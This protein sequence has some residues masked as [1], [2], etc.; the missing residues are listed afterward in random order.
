MRESDQKHQKELIHVPIMPMT[1]GEQAWQD[2]GSGH[3]IQGSEQCC[4][5]YS[6][7]SARAVQN[8]GQDFLGPPRV[9]LRTEKGGVAHLR[10]RIF[11]RSEWKGL[12]DLKMVPTCQCETTAVQSQGS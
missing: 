6:S 1:R 8:D 12:P 2:P 11:S 9:L 4:R 3:D 7:S 5:A 10:E